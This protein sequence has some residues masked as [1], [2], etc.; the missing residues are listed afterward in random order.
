MLTVRSTSR[1]IPRLL[2]NQKI[3]YRSHK[4][5]SATCPYYDQMSPVHIIPYFHKI[6]FNI[7]FHL[8]LSLA[9]GLFP[10]GFPVKKIHPF[11]IFPRALPVFIYYLVYK[12]VPLPTCRRQW[13][14]KCSSYSLI[15]SLDRGEW[16]AS[17][18][19]RALPPGKDPGTHWIGCW[20]GPRAGLDTDARG[21]ILFLCWRSIPGRPSL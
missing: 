14:E 4:I 11:L 8:H 1:E 16:S 15:S 3:H 12:D 7:I 20:V 2:W 21:K 6:S 9:S 18:S 17:R 13:G 5:Q 19:C 10:Q